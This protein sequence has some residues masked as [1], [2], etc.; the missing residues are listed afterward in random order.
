MKLLR[1]GQQ[2]EERV[3]LLIKLTSIRSENITEGLIWHLVKGHRVETAAALAQVKP[4]LLH[5]ALAV[6]EEV[7]SVIDEIKKLDKFSR[8]EDN[9]LPDN[10]PVDEYGD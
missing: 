10:V 4:S 7:E 9:G 6:L 8:F 2:S 3:T 5:R 1:P